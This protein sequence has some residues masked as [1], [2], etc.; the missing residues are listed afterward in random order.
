MITFVT[1]CECSFTGVAARLTPIMKSKGRGVHINL[2][3]EH[4]P[5]AHYHY[6]QVLFVTVIRT[7]ISARCGGVFAY[8]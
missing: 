3:E 6:R 7:W 1:T 8:I 5:H 2:A 4:A